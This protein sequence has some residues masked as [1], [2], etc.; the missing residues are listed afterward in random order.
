MLGRNKIAISCSQVWKCLF[1]MIASFVCLLW[2][3]LMLSADDEESRINLINDLL[4]ADVHQFDIPAYSSDKD[5]YYKR[6]LGY[7]SNSYLPP[8]VE[9]QHVADHRTIDRLK[10]NYPTFYKLGDILRHWPAN[11]TN[12][13]YWK[14]SPAHP[15]R[16]GGLYR[17]NFMNETEMKLALVLRDIALPY[18][19]YN[20]PELDSAAKHTFNVDSLLE[21]FGHHPRIIEQSPNNEFT[22]YTV[23]NVPI[24]RKRFP[25]WRPPQRDVSMTF[26][27]FVA[28][29]ARAEK[30]H[31]NDISGDESLFYMIINANEVSWRYYCFQTSHFLMLTFF[32][33]EQGLNGFDLLCRCLNLWILCLCRRKNLIVV[34]VFYSSIELN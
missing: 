19:I 16:G 18:V 11:H 7:N 2:V 29:V 8:D 17:L 26:K 3:Y 23:K 32:Q 33:R 12:K 1:I 5:Q 14:T 21:K 15:S 34:R 31:K 9:L 4:E 10:S 28:E 27:Q 25:D 22:Y 20:V 24:T 13:H 30:V 6:F